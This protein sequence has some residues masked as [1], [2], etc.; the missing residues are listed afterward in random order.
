MVFAQAGDPKKALAEAQA[1]HKAGRLDEAAQK[2]QIALMA[3]PNDPAALY[4]FAALETG[5]HRHDK[6][7]GLLERA[8]AAAPRERKILAGLAQVYGLLERHDDAIRVL[9]QVQ[10]LAPRDGAVLMDRA[11]ALGKAKRYAEAADAF[12][13]LAKAA[14]KE[15]GVWNNLGNV[16]V[17]LEDHAGAIEAFSNALALKPEDPMLHYGLG[18]AQL[19]AGA[20]EE[21]LPHLSAGI[22]QAPDQLQMIS[23]KIL[24]LRHLGRHEAADELEGLDDMV[25][26]VDVAPPDGFASLADFN[27]AL[28]AEIQN[29]SKLTSEFENRATRNGAKLDGMFAENRSPLF[30]AFEMQTRKAFEKTLDRMPR[31]QGHPLP[32]EI[33]GGSYR[34]DMWANVMYRGGHQ[35]PH[36]HPTGWFSACYYNVVPEAVDVSGDA[37]EGWIEFGGAAYDLPAPPDAPT[38]RIKPEPGLM[39]VFP[40][41]VFHRTIPFDSDEIRISTAFDAKPEAWLRRRSA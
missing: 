37:N 5:R 21:S 9:E 27:D 17:H 19:L 41:Y 40:S 2:Y 26:S 14:P 28:S 10:A 23:Y 6:A 1:A 35:R 16:L 30:E 3:A 12:R 13:T 20:Y 34:M 32:V 39:V 33:E 31:R 7:V 36:N 15:A 18:R 11:I 38:R 4:S 25:L 8:A 29:H 22:E 24:A